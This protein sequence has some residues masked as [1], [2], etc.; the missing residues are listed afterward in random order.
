VNFAFLAGGN[1]SGARLPRLFAAFRCRCERIWLRGLRRVFGFDAWH[2]SAAYSCR[3]YKRSVVEL[4]NSL[5]PVT[6]V[7]VGCGLGDILSRVNAAERFG[8]DIDTAVIRAAR[9]L[10]PGAARWIRGDT[11]SISLAIP[12]ERRIDCLIMVNWI[13]TLSPQQ[14]A[15][16]IL[17]LLPRTGYLILDAIDPDGPSSY[18]FKHDFSFL[19]TFAQRLSST[20]AA[21]EPRSFIVFKVTG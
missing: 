13:H 18:R 8:F 3:P 15:A 6:V 16:C 10:H 2:V 19:S 1:A 7:E 4:V 20:R 17:P 5:R 11:S 9:F 21:A 14:L 12:E